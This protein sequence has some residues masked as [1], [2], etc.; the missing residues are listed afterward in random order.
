MSGK[1][2]LNNMNI[3]KNIN[4]VAVVKGQNP[5]AVMQML[6]RTGYQVVGHNRMSEALELQAQLPRGLTWHF[7]GKLQS[8]KIAKIVETFD[9]IQSLENLDQAA[10]IAEALDEG[11]SYPVYL[12]VNI[13][14]IEERSGCVPEDVDMVLEGLKKYPALRVIGLMGMA[15][16]DAVLARE[17]F[18]L[19]KSLCPDSLECS[20]GMS[21]DYEIALEEGSTMLRLGRMLFT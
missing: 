21:G 12:Q 11:V 1:L 13:S 2:N 17:E 7:L 5:D 6:E 10:L 19:L 8:R 4:V 20:M 9:V 16:Q 14:G 18:R 3:P 15:S